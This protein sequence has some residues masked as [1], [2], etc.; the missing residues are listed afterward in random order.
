MTE[1]VREGPTGHYLMDNSNINIVNVL[2]SRVI[3]AAVHAIG[4]KVLKK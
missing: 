2:N 3:I 1:R 4:M